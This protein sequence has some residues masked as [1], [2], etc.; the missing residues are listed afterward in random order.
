MAKSLSEVLG[1][2]VLTGVIQDTRG[3]VPSEWLPPAFTTMTRPVKGDQATYTL[4]RSSRKTARMVHR[5]APSK[6]RELSGVAVKPIK[7][8]NFYEHHIHRSEIFDAIRN[9]DNPEVQAMGQAEIDRKTREFKQI[10]DNTRVSMIASMFP[11]VSSQI[12]GPVVAS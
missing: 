9:Y 3:G 4:I 2:E 7:L 5:G 10:Y 12:S 1:A 6:A 11:S 8:A